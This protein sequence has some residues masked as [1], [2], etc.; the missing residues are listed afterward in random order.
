MKQARFLSVVGLVLAFATA[1]A[2]NEGIA[3][4]STAASKEITNAVAGTRSGAAKTVARSLVATPEAA[5]ATGAQT[6]DKG[7]KE[8]GDGKKA[9]G[10]GTTSPKGKIV[11]PPPG[12]Q[13]GQMRCHTT[14]M[15]RGAAERNRSRREAADRNAGAAGQKNEGGAK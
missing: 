4:A 5:A 11:G 8:S 7:G 1:W 10:G 9:D 2:M 3:A 14:N 13:P 6:R 15:R 12:C